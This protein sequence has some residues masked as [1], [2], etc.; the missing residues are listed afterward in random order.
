MGYKKYSDEFKREVPEMVARGNPRLPDIT[1]WRGASLLFLTN[2]LSIVLA[3]WGVIFWVGMRPRRV[4]TSRM[5]QVTSL[6][7][8]AGLMFAVSFLLVQN[9]DPRTYEIGA[10][11]ALNSAFGDSEVVSFGIRR[12]D[13]L[14]VI[15]TVRVSPELR[16]VV[17][18]EVRVLTAAEQRIRA[19]LM[20]GFSGEV[21]EML[22]L[23][24]VEDPSTRYR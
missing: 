7:L 3:A 1:L 19:T 18:P 15:A 20:A 13:P 14:R 24:G 17:Q 21:T 22:I 6:V 11:R 8:V 4:E 9:V 23:D 2:I 5:R 12:D 16:V 10:D